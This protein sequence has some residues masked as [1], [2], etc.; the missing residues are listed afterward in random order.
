MQDWLFWI[1]NE[2]IKAVKK[3]W[4]I[5]D[6]FQNK[7][8]LYSLY[9]QNRFRSI[10]DNW[11]ILKGLLLLLVILFSLFTFIVG[12]YDGLMKKRIILLILC[13]LFVIVFHKS[14]KKNALWAPYLGLFINSVF[15]F[16]WTE[17]TVNLNDFR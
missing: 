7:K 9:Y 10:H 8:E 2:T 6:I 15:G 16:Y 17:I 3:W 1:P 4:N 5:S 13:I 14:T 11:K 12:P